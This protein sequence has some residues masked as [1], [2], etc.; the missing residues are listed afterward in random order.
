M[1]FPSARD[2]GV[3]LCSSEPL[4]PVNKATTTRT[5]KYGGRGYALTEGPGWVGAGPLG[6]CPSPDVAAILKPSQTPTCRP[7]RPPL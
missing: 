7:K 6:L 3:G 4:S 5:T 1:N 2:D